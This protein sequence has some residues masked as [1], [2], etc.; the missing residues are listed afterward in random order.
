MGGKGGKSSPPA[1]ALPDASA[2]GAQFEQM[3]TALLQMQAA[4]ANAQPQ[5]PAN[6]ATPEVVREPVVN[7]AEKN[8]ELLAKSRAD[9]TVNQARKKGRSSTVL[10]SPLLD[11]TA[12]STTDSLLAGSN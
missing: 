9:Y 8:A 6:P 7:W 10:T 3:M 2:Q 11:E 4:A 5:A 1:P 12:A